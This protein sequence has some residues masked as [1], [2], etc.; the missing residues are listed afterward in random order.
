MGR[1]E[2]CFFPS[3]SLS[4]M[5][6][7]LCNLEE[8]PTAELAD[9]HSNCYGFIYLRRFDFDTCQP[10]S[11]TSLFGHLCGDNNR[12]KRWP[13]LFLYSL[14]RSAVNDRLTKGGIYPSGQ[15]ASAS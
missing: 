1:S 11:S 3:S 15:N 6:G 9:H 13:V 2:H 4:F 8:V 5:S 12:S 7:Q 14:V 10:P